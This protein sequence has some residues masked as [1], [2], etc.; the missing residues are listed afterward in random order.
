MKMRRDIAENL[1][2]SIGQGLVSMGEGAL[3]R[4]QYNEWASKYLPEGKPEQKGIPYENA[5]D[6][7]LDESA[8]AEL[9]TKLGNNRHAG[10]YLAGAQ[11]ALGQAQRMQEEQRMAQ[12]EQARKRE[13]EEMKRL[14]TQMALNRAMY[15]MNVSMGRTPSPEAIPDVA[16]ALAGQQEMPQQVRTPVP[17]GEAGDSGLPQVFNERPVWQEPQPEQPKIKMTGKLFEQNGQLVQ[18]GYDEYGNEHLVPLPEGMKPYEKP[19]GGGGGGG[20]ELTFSQDMKLQDVHRR[21]RQYG[22]ADLP[23]LYREKKK[24][25]K[26]PT[27]QEINAAMYSGDEEAIRKFNQKYGPFIKP[28]YSKDGME[29]IGGELMP[30]A[31][32]REEALDDWQYRFDEAKSQYKQ[33]T[34]LVKQHG[35]M[36]Y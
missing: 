26:L 16:R 25:A 21:R 32:A 5:G 33:D 24:I 18:L 6:Y 7:T 23:K 2:R 1:V 28:V 13:M 29:V 9:V 35:N 30:G 3:A 15:D 31:V 14:Q 22:Q 8:M 27:Q 20:R 11:S 34:E 12:E 19:S 17:F 10:P 4:K 36:E